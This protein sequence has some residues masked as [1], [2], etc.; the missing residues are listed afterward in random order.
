MNKCFR[1]LL[2]VC[3]ITISLLAAI[4]AQAQSTWDGGGANANW[5]TAGNWVGDVAPTAGATTDLEFG[6]T[7]QLSAVNNFASG[8]LFRNITFNS[9]A[10]AF[11]LSGNNIGTTG[12]ALKLAITNNSALTQ[13]VTNNVA[14]SASSSAGLSLNSAVG[15]GGL[16]FGGNISGGSS[17]NNFGL[18]L[19]NVS[20]VSSIRLSGT[21]SSTSNSVVVS[22]NHVNVVEVASDTA[23]S[24]ILRMRG[25]Q[26]VAFGGPRTISRAVDLNT[27]DAISLSLAGENAFTFTSALSNNG[28]NAGES[29]IFNTGAVTTLSGGLASSSAAANPLRA[30]NLAGSGSVILSGNLIN[31]SGGRQTGLAWNNSQ[32]LTVSGNATAT[33]VTQ[34]MG[35]EVVLDFST[36]NTQKTTTG[37]LTLG[38]SKIS[39]SGG[40]FTNTSASTTLSRG[41]TTVE[42]P[43]GASV[44]ALN[45]ITR[46]A[47]NGAT[48]AFAADGLATTDR[49]NTNGIL[50][51]WAVV[52]DNWAINS[53][54]A[55]DGSITGLT[56]YQS[57]V[58]D[59]GANQNV[60][61]AG[62]ATLTASRVHNSLKIAPTG[63]GESLDLGASQ[64]LDLTS[65]GLLFTGSNAYTISNGTLQAV[66]SNDDLKVFV[67]GTGD[68]TIN[69]VIANGSG[70]NGLTKSGAG[71][72]V[73]GGTNTFTGSVVINQGAVSV[74]S[75][76]ALGS[77]TSIALHG[78]SLRLTETFTLTRTGGIAL[79]VDGGSIDVASGK[80]VTLAADLV[81]GVA[82]YANTTL[83]SLTKSGAG[84]LVVSDS[85]TYTGATVLNEGVLSVSSIKDGAE[86]YS[87]T[88]GSG[89]AAAS[90]IGAS[91]GNYRNLVFNGGT[92]RYTGAAASS[93]RGFTI[94]ANGGTLDASGSGALNFTGGQIFLSGSNTARS[95][96]LAGTHA[97]A[98]TLGGS[99]GDN[100]TGAT[101]LVKS[102]SGTW[103]LTGSSTYSGGTLI[104]AGTLLVNNP[105]GS[106]TGTGSVVVQTAG[107]LGGNGTISGAV[108]VEGTLAPGNSIESLSTGALTIT[109]TGTLDI[110]LGRSSGTPVSDRVKVTG[111]VS[112]ASGA[113]LKLTLYSGLTSPQDG[114]LFFLVDNDG[115]DAVSGV[116]TKLNGINTTLSE[117]SVFTWNSWQ[118][119]ISYE[120]NVGTAAFT[121]GN[122]VAILALAAVPEPGAWSLAAFAGAALLIFRRR[123]SRMS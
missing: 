24:G 117:G 108:S 75:A 40:S 78:G 93:N 123:R 7:T 19:S 42:R 112:L 12:V 49:T 45:A 89:G 26:L 77:G 4:S 116:F 53:T 68:L 90:G 72:L 85:N 5:N 41:A 6:G 103:V 20:G 81:N 60:A 23:F 30:V 35:G 38:G 94:G 55:A 51:G 56:T 92:L 96:T 43:S 36:N 111:V 107:K 106:G 87:G 119:Q 15:G 64:S 9:D 83:G 91:T 104:N 65:G 47:G 100:G 105:T 18:N 52:G 59:T 88:Y 70:I 27:P 13:T 3:C 28:N 121:G 46:A 58:N 110:E 63:A 113:N 82:D 14:Y 71:T 97:G 118:W 31:G 1:S 95:F 50:G 54:N 32:D 67:N 16:V 8:S 11:T 37:A 122:D 86:F 98:N 10:G 22:A 25:A 115:S 80:T 34:L 2:V 102:G 69:S 62:N 48:V 114:D 17:N 109:S 73:L 39:L 33:G 84:T 76:A 44:L 99:L 120:A 79:G 61:V 21:N 66:T 29:V 101:S 74:A 57:D